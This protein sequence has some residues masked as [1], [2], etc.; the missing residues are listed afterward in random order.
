MSS[1]CYALHEVVLLASSS[2]IVEAMWMG[3]SRMPPSF[4]HDYMQHSHSSAFKMFHNTICAGPFVIEQSMT[5]LAKA[6]RHVHVIHGE[7][8]ATCSVECGVALTRK[9]PNVTLSRIAGADHMSVVLGREQEL[10]QELE[11]QILGHYQ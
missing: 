10:A 3:L 7:D 4:I 9:F 8:D 6:G 1:L 11:A 2:L 5:Q